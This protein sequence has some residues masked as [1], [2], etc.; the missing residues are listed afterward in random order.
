MQI[1]FK[2]VTWTGAEGMNLLIK[3]KFL[4]IYLP[5]QYI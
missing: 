5:F 3:I 2:S 1:S 4:S